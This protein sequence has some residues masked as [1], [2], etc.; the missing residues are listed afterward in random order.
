MNRARAYLVEAFG[1]LEY[2]RVSE[3]K[4]LVRLAIG[5]VDELLQAAQP[6]QDVRVVRALP[7]GRWLSANLIE[8]AALTMED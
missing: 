6:G 1:L 3:A 4:L 7:A 5:E 2:N 8:R